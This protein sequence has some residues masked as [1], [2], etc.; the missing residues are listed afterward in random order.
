M[1]NIKAYGAEVGDALQTKSIQAAIDACFLAGGG[2]VIVPCGVFRTGSIRLR[3]N[4]TLHLMRGA[5]LEGSD[6]P[7]DY[8]DYLNDEI[9]PITISKEER[10]SVNPHS[11]WHNAI[12][13]V[14]DAEN[15]SIIGEEGSYIFGV[16]C[17]DAMGEEGYRGPHAIHIHNS[18]NITLRGY[19][20]K[21]SANWAHN[22][23]NTQNIVVQNV[24]AYGGHDGFDV[25]TCDNILI[26]NCNFT[27]GDDGIAGFD[28][29]NVE[30]KNCVMCSSCNAVRFG[31]TDVR[32]SNCKLIGPA[33][34][35]HRWMMDE[36][37][38]KFGK[39]TEE[40]DRHNSLSAFTYYCDFRADVRK[41]PGN[42]VFENCEIKN[43][44]KLLEILFNRQI[45]CCNKPLKSLKFKNCIISGLKETSNVYGDK[46]Y[47]ITIEFEDC[48]IK[49]D[50]KIPFIKIAYFD[51]LSF[52]NT[53]LSGFADV[54]ILVDV[55]EN[56]YSDFDVKSEISEEL[57]ESL[58]DTKIYS[59]YEK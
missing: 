11:R 4:V 56:I 37:R 58:K 33:K 25:R 7:E 31:G 53:K 29:I 40:T 22:I 39:M 28:N 42:M 1:Y 24:T 32:I 55:N 30:V 6:N 47:P 2:E 26:E 59:P 51:K 49:A 13:K 18:K 5:I 45:W 23:E 38:K 27:T 41:L 48:D 52:S 57:I 17:Y 54:P 50:E 35:G 20:I 34:F 16:N 46:E 19:I 3:S 15:V 9:E 36:N 21:D 12:I 8:M 43:I 44:D 10:R 14:L